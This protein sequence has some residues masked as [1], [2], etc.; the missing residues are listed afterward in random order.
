LVTFIDLFHLPELKERPDD[1]KKKL[2]HELKYFDDETT[3][4]LLKLIKAMNVTKPKK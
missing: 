1:F 2:A 4:A 3:E